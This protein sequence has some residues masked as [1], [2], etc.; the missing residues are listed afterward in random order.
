ME[1][2]KY[3]DQFV[4]MVNELRKEDKFTEKQIY[5][6]CFWN[7]FKNVIEDMERDEEV[8]YK[9]CLKIDVGSFPELEITK[10]NESKI[11]E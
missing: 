10:L 6:K 1:N 4:D 11:F 8:E 7:T 2:E 9:P 5:G 3:V